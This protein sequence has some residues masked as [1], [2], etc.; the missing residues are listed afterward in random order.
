MI[1]NSNVGVAN[2]G[3][4]LS[5]PA[6]NSVADRPARCRTS[7]YRLTLSR[8]APW[9]GGAS[10]TIRLMRGSCLPLADLVAQIISHHQVAQA[11]RDEIKLFD[12][13]QLI[14]DASQ[15]LG[16]GADIGQGAGVSHVTIWNLPLS[17][18]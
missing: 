12:L 15:S 10:I 14:H 16:M 8:L 5:Q 2:F 11:V 7:R 9:F 3:S 13:G 18:R 1:P 17:R 4:M 6:P